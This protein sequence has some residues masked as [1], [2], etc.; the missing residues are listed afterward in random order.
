MKNK[1]IP[2]LDKLFLE[3]GTYRKSN[4]L[5]ELFEFVKKFPHIAPY[6]AMLIHIQKPGSQYVATAAEW[7]KKFNRNINPGARPL[8]ILRL[9]GPVSFVFELSDTFGKAPFPE[10][11][12]NPFKV[13]GQVANVVFNRL[14]NNLKSDGILYSEVDHGTSS[15]GF[16]Q[17]SSSQ[18]EGKILRSKKEIWVKI[19]YEMVVNRTHPQETRFATIL[20][21]LAHV[22]CGHLGTPNP[23]WWGDRRHLDKNE[24][25]FEAESVCWL[26]CERRGLKNPSAEYLNGYLKD[27][28]EIPNISIDTV[29][30]SVAIIESMLKSN[31][32]PRKEI[33]KRINEI[34]Q[35]KNVQLS[36]NFNIT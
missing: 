25:E 22:Y 31:K 20:H 16:I 32:E 30:K 7:E 21:E 13:K 27:N 4:E 18:R 8:V 35:E 36:L 11:L 2:E 29:L 6:N 3:I 14:I 34:K 17:I 5:K 33:V 23:K 10:E 15:A 1:S 12:I 28:K 19:L 26:V 24:R 9:F